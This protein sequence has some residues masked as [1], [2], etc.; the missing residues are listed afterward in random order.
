LPEGSFV[1]LQKVVKVRMK[2]K[3]SVQY[4]RGAYLKDVSAHKFVTLDE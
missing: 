1:R 2:A 4:A 3:F